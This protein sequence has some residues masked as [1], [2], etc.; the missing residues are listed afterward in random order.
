MGSGLHESS[1]RAY[2]CAQNRTF[3]K[4]RPHGKTVSVIIIFEPRHVISN[5]VAFDDKCRLR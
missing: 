2:T 4:K 3:F 1:L 5:N